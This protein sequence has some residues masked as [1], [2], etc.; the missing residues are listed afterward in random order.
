LRAG[1]LTIGRLLDVFGS[2]LGFGLLQRD[3]G[4]RVSAALADHVRGGSVVG[5][6]VDPGTERAAPVKAIEAPPQGQ[7]NLL[8]EIA[9]LVPIRPQYVAADY[10]SPFTS[11][12]YFFL[13]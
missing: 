3:Q 2:G 6:A 8:Q 4:R 13:S 5:H 11:S 9:A 1:P 10:L 7:M 12:G